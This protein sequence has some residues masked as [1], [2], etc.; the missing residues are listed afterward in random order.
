[1]CVCVHVLYVSVCPLNECIKC[2]NGSVKTGAAIIEPMA[3]VVN[4][5]YARVSYACVSARHGEHGRRKD[6]QREQKK[7]DVNHTL[8]WFR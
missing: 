7:T 8:T 1:V 3:T 5:I 6:K 4:I 2:G